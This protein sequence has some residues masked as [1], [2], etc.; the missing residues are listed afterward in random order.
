MRVFISY[1]RDDSSGY[2]GRI[3]EHLARHFGEENVFMDIDTIQP[4]QDF[5]TVVNN[6]IKS[7]DVVIPIIGKQWVNIV[8]AKGYRRLDHPNDWV[9]KEISIALNRNVRVIP[10]LVGGASMPGFNELPNDVKSLAQRQAIELSDTRFPYD[11]GQLIK[12]IEGK[13]GK[14]T[15]ASTGTPE[16]KSQK[17]QGCLVR[18][19]DNLFSIA[20]VILLGGGGMGIL[21]YILYPEDFG[22]TESFGLVLILIGGVIS[23]IIAVAINKMTK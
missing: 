1:R 16:V 4:G 14:V 7:C 12:H 11:M 15:Y 23:A 9:R 19:A 21:S 5:T 18:F 22:L 3:Y 2:A 10:L 17:K 8:D 6:A 20:A 13:G